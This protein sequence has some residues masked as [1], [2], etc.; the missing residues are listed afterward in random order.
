MSYVIYT[1]YKGI[2]GFVHQD[3][4]KGL[5]IA[6]LDLAKRFDSPESAHE[7]LTRNK[8]HDR[9]FVLMSIVEEVK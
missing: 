2:P 1:R 3:E 4:E 9:E 8:H 7:Y 5:P 6:Y